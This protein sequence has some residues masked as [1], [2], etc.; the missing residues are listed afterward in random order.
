MQILFLPPPAVTKSPKRTIFF[1]LKQYCGRTQQTSPTITGNQHHQI[2]QIPTSQERR[3]HRRTYHHRMPEPSPCMVF[4]FFILPPPVRSWDENLDPL[5]YVEPLH[6]HCRTRIAFDNFC[7]PRIFRGFDCL[8]PFGI[9][10][11]GG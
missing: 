5:L 4:I 3:D 1:P 9:G 6:I 7:L 2:L 11:F 8:R 10:F